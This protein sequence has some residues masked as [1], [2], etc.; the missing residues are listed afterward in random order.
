MHSIALSQVSIM[1]KWSAT[2]TPHPAQAAHHQHVRPA[3]QLNTRLLPSQM[4]ISKSLISEK[5]GRRT[6]APVAAADLR[7]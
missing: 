6:S 3:V 7:A 1:P 4:L 5:Q 2:S